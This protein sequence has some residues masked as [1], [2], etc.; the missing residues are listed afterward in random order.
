MTLSRRLF[1]AG[2]AML[3]LTGTAEARSSSSKSSRSSRRSTTRSSTNRRRTEDCD[4]DDWLEGD[5]DCH[6]KPPPAGLTQQ[7]FGRD[8]QP[9]LLDRLFGN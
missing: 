5:S 4:R 8:R 6:G 7:D 2:I 9:G 1:G 3:C